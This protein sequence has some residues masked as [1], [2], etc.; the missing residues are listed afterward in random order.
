MDTA[1]WQNVILPAIIT[2]LINM[3]VVITKVIADHR[4][5]KSEIKKID[6]ESG[7]LEID[8]E[9]TATEIWEQL[10]D[11]VE[12]RCKAMEERMGELDKS[13]DEL[14][15][16]LEIEKNARIALENKVEQIK[17]WFFRNQ[18]KLKEAGIEPI[19]IEL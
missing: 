17:N 4:K 13:R 6:A 10:Y 15:K 2:I 16:A 11:K 14:E 18:K 9:K 1:L 3:A 19:P 12:A 8:T 7:K 5:S